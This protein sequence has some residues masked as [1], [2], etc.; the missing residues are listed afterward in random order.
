MKF[1]ATRY[2][3]DAAYSE[4]FEAESV[5]EA[6][7][8]CRQNGWLLDGVLVATIPYD[9]DHPIPSMEVH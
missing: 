8:H 6:E 2:E 9:K 4:Q 1:L 5:D 7:E 3:A